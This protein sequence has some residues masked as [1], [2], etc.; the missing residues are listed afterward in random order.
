MKVNRGWVRLMALVGGLALT[1]AEAPWVTGAAPPRVA[2]ANRLMR[3]LKAVSDRVPES[4][5]RKLSGGALN[6]FALAERWDQVE[7]QL[8]HIASRLGR[9]SAVGCNKVSGLIQVS[10]PCADHQGFSKLPG[11]IQSETSTAWCGNNVVVGFNDNGSY[12]ESLFFGPGGL[13][14]LGV[15][16]STNRGASFTDL[17]Y[18]NP[19]ASV[20]N[21]LFSDPVLG[22]KDENT[23]YYAALFFNLTD[24]ISAISVSTST[25]GGLSFGDP[26][27]AVAKD[28]SMHLLD[29]PWFAI[30]P[31]DTN[32][33]FV[34]YTDFDGTGVN[35]PFTGQQRIAIELVRSTDGGATW[36]APVALAEVCSPDEAMGS[37][38]VVGSAGEV[39]VAWEASVSDFDIRREI[40]IRRSLNGGQTFEPTVKV[41]DVIPVG[42]GGLLQGGFRIN[43]F[44]SLA[45][46]RSGKDTDGFAYIAW[47]D[48]RFLT[49]GTYGYAD[50][51]VSRSTDGG[52]TW[53]APTKLN[54][55][56]EPLPSG[57][58]TDQYQPGIAVNKSGKVGVCFYDR[59]R[60]RNNLLIDR[61]CAKSSNAG[62]SFRNTRMT[63][64]RFAPVV[65]LGVID[66][67]YMGDYDSLA[68]DFTQA[69][70]N[71]IGAFA[72][73][74]AGNPDVKA[75]EF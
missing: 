25:D 42:E 38:V 40:D 16:R 22:C 75:N 19:G 34:T 14:G 18:V 27:S 45:V 55:N 35:C 39:Y 21:L 17:G 32:T 37:Q 67:T 54:T 73:N 61:E 66:P 10:D 23:F 29:K 3:Q 60:D 11:V 47:N 56:I 31:T 36:S 50:V 5:R 13:S 9:A 49:V 58:G 7:P 20:G 70:G 24:S 74:S 63:R 65:A 52:T 12:F 43:E 1:G 46:D 4:M 15:A 57:L 48:A 68:T 72:D 62:I 51:L 8:G 30:D 2:A 69:F 44:P 71:F 64:K 53:S 41:A 6:A 28:L 33:L 26:V 59:R